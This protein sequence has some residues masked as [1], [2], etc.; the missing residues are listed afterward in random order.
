M[1]FRQWLEAM[2]SEPPQGQVIIVSN[3]GSKIT[4]LLDGDP[5]HG[6][7]EAYKSKN[8]SGE[9]M[10]VIEKS[11]ATKGYGPLIYDI[12]IEEI[13]ANGG[14]AV[15]DRKNVSPDAFGVWKYYYFKRPDVTQVPLSVGQWYAGKWAE[16][17]LE[18]LSDDESSRPPKDNPIWALWTGYK[19]Q[20]TLVPKLEKEGKL[21]RR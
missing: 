15:S 5:V 2:M 19:K 10:Y 12:M 1:E 14:Y 13:T 8:L 11:D 7:A 9:P 21:V 17:Y 18:K 6:A 3:K 20:P 4:V 16:P